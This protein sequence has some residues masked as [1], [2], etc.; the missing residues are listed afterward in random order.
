MAW[1]NGQWFADMARC[2][3]CG[4]FLKRGIVNVS[5]HTVV[6]C[7]E[8]ECIVWGTGDDGVT[9][10][11]MKKKKNLNRKTY[12]QWN[13]FYDPQR[14]DTKIENEKSSIL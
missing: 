6:E 7:P 14:S 5:R 11:E 1:I 4:R 3:R 8:S 2:P 10:A 12:S 13:V 9:R